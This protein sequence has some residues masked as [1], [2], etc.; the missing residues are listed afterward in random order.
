MVSTDNPFG[1]DLSGGMPD[2][3]DPKV[4]Q[5]LAQFQQMMAASTSKSGPVNWDMARQLAENAIRAEDPG[6]DGVARTKATEALRL[7][8]LWLDPTTTLPSGL[9][10]TEAW[11]RLDWIAGTIETWKRLCDPVATKMV[12]S[13]GELVPEDMKAMLGPMADIM[14]GL[15]SVMFGSQLGNALAGL[16]TEVLTSTEIGLPLG[17]TGTAALIPANLAAYG[18]DHELPE[19]EVRLYMALREAAHHRLFSHVPW[20]RAYVLGTV[21]SYASGIHIDA[22]AVEDAVSE[23]DPSRPETMQGL[24]LSDVL[25]PTDTPA[26]KAA[27][28]R[29]ETVLALIAGWVTT[30]VEEAAG[31]RLPALHRLAELFQ[32]R[33]AA[34]GPAEQTFAT[35]V[36]L[37][38]RPKRLREA[39][40]LWKKLTEA[41]GVEG[42]DA[43]WEHPDLLPDAEALSDP[44]AWVS[45]EGFEFGDIDMSFFEESVKRDGE[46]GSDSDSTPD[47][48]S[49]EEGPESGPANGDEPKK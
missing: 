41:K 8:D 21:E 30:V 40:V 19:D 23:I 27:L 16:A 1:F 38:L 11:S 36:G 3:N 20:L 46:S 15:G 33:R 7:A 39:V 28:T 35:L 26:Q 49:D 6:V 5:M 37:E 48:G 34:G 18:A 32:R 44:D 4:R 9:S 29:L 45:G 24:D 22:S 12:A 14:K 10:A 47:A 25:K 13:M 31:D 42:R 2:P 43:I 17:P